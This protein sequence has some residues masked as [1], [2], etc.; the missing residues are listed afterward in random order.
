MESPDLIQ[1]ISDET[2]NCR[3]I[4]GVAPVKV[5]FSRQPYGCDT[6]IMIRKSKIEKH[7]PLWQQTLK[8]SYRAHFL[9]AKKHPAKKSAVQPVYG[10]GFKLSIFGAFPKALHEFT[11]RVEKINLLFKKVFDKSPLLS[12]CS[13]INR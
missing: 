1:G 8:V 2:G 11:M 10:C 4:E 6:I 3:H 5:I 9:Q 12:A 13:H 7:F